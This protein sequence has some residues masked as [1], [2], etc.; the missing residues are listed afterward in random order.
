M[1]ICGR[2]TF[3]FLYKWGLVEVS[4][5]SIALYNRKPS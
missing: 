2:E 1:H 5:K 4:Y 3:A